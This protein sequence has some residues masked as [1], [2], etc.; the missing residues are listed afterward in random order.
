MNAGGSFNNVDTHAQLDAHNNYPQAAETAQ[1]QNTT[2]SDSDR[3]NNA[4]TGQY[5][6]ASGKGGHGPSTVPAARTDTEAIAPAHE[7]GP[8]LA[9]TASQQPHMG[10]GTNTSTPPSTWQPISKDHLTSSRW[11]TGSSGQPSDPSTN[12]PSY[13]NTLFANY[14]KPLANS[15]L[16]SRS[17]TNMANLINDPQHDGLSMPATSPIS[18]FN[19]SPPG[20]F[21]GSF[22]NNIPDRRATMPAIDRT[23]P[24]VTSISSQHQPPSRPSSLFNTQSSSQIPSR[25]LPQRYGSLFR[26]QSGS[27]IAAAK[28]Q[29][30]DGTV[31]RTYSSLFSAPS[32]HNPAYAS[33]VKRP[34]T[35]TA[36]VAF[37]PSPENKSNF[38]TNIFPSLSTS[39]KAKAKK[40]LDFLEKRLTNLER[41]VKATDIQVLQID[42]QLALLRA[43][44]AIQLTSDEQLRYESLQKSK[45]IAHV[46]RTVHS[47][48]FSQAQIALERVY[49]NEV[50][51]YVSFLGVLVRVAEEEDGAVQ[52]AVEQMSLAQTRSSSSLSSMNNRPKSLFSQESTRSEE[53]GP[54]GAID[55]AKLEKLLNTIQ[56]DTITTQK[57]EDRIGT[58][59][60]L[61][62]T[63]LE[64]Q[65]IGLGWMQRMEASVKGGILGDDMGLGKTI[66]M[67]YVLGT[68]PAFLLT[69]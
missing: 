52:R 27:N 40:V 15:S 11:P 43:Q 46:Q 67:M 3:A 35:L 49:K 64:H 55:R 16:N 41:L 36:P 61:K 68:L 17:M 33:P 18:S 39:N 6:S 1:A 57:P 31:K 29:P 45:R 59:D 53:Y 21:A 44:Q 51:D 42:K 8:P 4:K 14:S 9:T 48:N 2:P 37:Q 50:D 10:P 69:V 5:A 56:S 13:N 26:S 20:S 65:K 28:T 19:S 32:D 54:A 24:S 38:F 7:P 66:Q 22:T 62:I 63:L 30:S 47:R 58:P 34:R 60:E 25:S 23:N 12:S